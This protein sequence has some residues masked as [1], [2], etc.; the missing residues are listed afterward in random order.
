MFSCLV[1]TSSVVGL[2]W[3]DNVQPAIGR[4]VVCGGRIDDVVVSIDRV[5]DVLVCM[6]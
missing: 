5:L 4:D 2:D 3:T 1:C 6:M